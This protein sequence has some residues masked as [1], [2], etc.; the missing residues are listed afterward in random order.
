MN[1]ERTRKI[2]A[3]GGGLNGRVTKDGIR[4]PYQTGVMDREIVK[5]T[6]K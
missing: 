6:E 1:L 3:I 5:L 2:V 4:E